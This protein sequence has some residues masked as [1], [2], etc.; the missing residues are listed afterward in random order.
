MSEDPRME[1]R[2]WKMNLILLR[3]HATSHWMKFREGGKGEK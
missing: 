2:L 1:Y 3:M